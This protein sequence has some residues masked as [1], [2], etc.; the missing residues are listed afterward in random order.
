M[1][2]ARRT[3]A[4]AKPRSVK[5]YMSDVHLRVH[6]RIE[7]ILPSLPPPFIPPNDST[8]QFFMLTQVFS[9]LESCT[10]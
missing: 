2:A 5:L 4:T 7:I 9:R 6:L 10:L 3:Y 1:H 8:D